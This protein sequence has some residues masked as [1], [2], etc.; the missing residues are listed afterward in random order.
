MLTLLY[1]KKIAFNLFTLLQIELPIFELTDLYAS[2]KSD[3]IEIVE[4]MLNQ[5]RNFQL[6]PKL[7]TGFCFY[8]NY[9]LGDV[10]SYYVEK[11]FLIPRYQNHSLRHQISVNLPLVICHFSLEPITTTLTIKPPIL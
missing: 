10:L 7:V 8:T 6:H 9:H 2:K 1:N 5:C 4:S 3:H 11:E